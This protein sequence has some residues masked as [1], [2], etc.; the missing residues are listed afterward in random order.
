[1]TRPVPGGRRRVDTV[2]D[3]AFVADLADLT[4]ADVRARRREAD[5]EDADLSFLR[6]LLQARIDL[7]RAELRARARADGDHLTGSAA[8][9]EQSD[10]DL[11]ARLTAALADPHTGAGAGHPRHLAAT[12]S[13]VE[14]H[15]R[16]PERAWADLS[17]SDL[18]SRSD[19]EL[20][21]ALERLTALEAEVSEVRLA[22]HRVAD[23][24]STET[25]RRYRDGEVEVEHA[26]RTGVLPGAQ[27]RHDAPDQP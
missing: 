24:L 20:G 4:L 19:E 22:V 8:G 2:L 14:E 11:V 17:L 9:G 5:Q 25:G 13:R 3:P 27:P 7:V 18:G 12:P 6:R 21:L 10:A 16:A 15:R 23:V 1:M 26:L